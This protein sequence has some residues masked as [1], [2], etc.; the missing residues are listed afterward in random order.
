VI[1]RSFQDL[2]DTGH[3]EGGNQ[4][5]V[6]VVAVAAAAQHDFLTPLGNNAKGRLDHTVNH[7]QWCGNASQIQSFQFLDNPIFENSAINPLNQFFAV[8]LHPRR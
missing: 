4:I 1:R 5:M 6:G 8:G 2:A 3:F 7:P